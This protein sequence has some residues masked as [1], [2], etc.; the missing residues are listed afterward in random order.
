MLIGFGRTTHT[1]YMYNLIP[2]E[3]INIFLQMD[4]FNPDVWI[5]L[6]GNIGVF[7]PFGILIPLV[8]KKRLFKSFILFFSAVLVL[9]TLQLV[10]RRG[11]F[12]I[13]DL[14]LNSL[15]FF[16]GYGLYRIFTSWGSSRSERKLGE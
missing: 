5:N 16:T 2:F 3:T 12:D 7:V 9:E 4:R 6:V 8:I 14:I 11:S 15:G 10:L 1:E 13:D